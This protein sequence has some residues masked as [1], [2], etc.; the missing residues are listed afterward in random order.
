M[1]K[2]TVAIL[3]GGCSSEYPVSLHSSYSVITS[4]NKSKYD[5][6]LIGV[7][8]DGVWYRYD[9]PV[10]LIAEDK[11]LDEK[12]CTKAII[13]PSRDDKGLVDL[14]TGQITKIDV[15]FPVFHGMNGEDGTI[16]GLLQLAGLPFVGPGCAASAASMD[17]AITKAMINQ[18]GT[19]NQADTCV[20]LKRIYEADKAAEMDRINKYFD[21]NYPLFVKPAN[22]GSSVGIT[23]VKGPEYLEEGLEKAFAVDDK[24][25]VEETIVGRE[26]EVAVLGNE[27]ARAS[28]I[29]EIFAANEFYDFDAK[30]TNAES[31]TGI[32]TDLSKE[33]EDEI[34]N[35]AIT[36][37]NVMG[38]KGLSRVDFFLQDDG[39]VVFNEL[40]TL[41]G[42]TS[43]SMYPQLWE[44]TGI[45][46]SQLIDELIQ[47]A[48]NYDNDKF[49]LE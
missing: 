33:K 24:L 29:G 26:I 39:K 7:T 18:N 35:A 14:T 21:G 17:K 5:I 13:S 46:Y 37:Y 41:P 44:A 15:A 30:Y 22:A 36:V 32:V 49:S 40:N 12:Y 20:S 31:R 4:I 48:L 16:Q 11:W 47:L 25:L 42:F 9:G 23:K 1:K 45:P 38:C 8:K 34:R 10:D 43:I 3:F 27:D 28:V 6:V 19:V 2:L